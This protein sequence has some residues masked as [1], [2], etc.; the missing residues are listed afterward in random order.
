MNCYIC[1][2]ETTDRGECEACR[3]DLHP[4]Q[5][6]MRDVTGDSSFTDH[7][8]LS[9]VNRTDADKITAWCAG[10]QLP[11]H[12]IRKGG[13]YQVA[14]VPNV[15]HR[16]VTLDMHST[17]ERIKGLEQRVEGLLHLMKMHAE[18]I[19][20]YRQEIENE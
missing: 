4:L 17:Q 14:R 7:G 20:E 18:I 9:A 16:F 11:Y 2:P 10:A 8:A 12:A 15:L 6:Y 13:N 19:E 5:E 3:Y 1:D